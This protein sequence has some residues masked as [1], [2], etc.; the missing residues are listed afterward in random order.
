MSDF[1]DESKHMS[2][3]HQEFAGTLQVDEKGRRFT[4]QN[5]EFIDEKGRR[6]SGYDTA[7]R[8]ISVVDDVFGEIK[9]GGPNYRDVSCRARFLYWCQLKAS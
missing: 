7:G 5:G 6:F 3:D 1:K 8:R 9:E 4:Q 2:R